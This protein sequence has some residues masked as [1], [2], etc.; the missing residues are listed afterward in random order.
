[1]IALRGAIHVACFHHSCFSMGV[2]RCLIE[3]VSVWEHVTSFSAQGMWWDGCAEKERN[4]IMY[5]IYGELLDEVLKVFPETNCR[6][7]LPAK[8]SMGVIKVIVFAFTICTTL[9]LWAYSSATIDGVTW[10]YMEKTDGT[11]EIGTESSSCAVVGFKTGVLS[12]PSEICDRP[13][14]GIGN[15]AFSECR[16]LTSVT[17]PSSVTSIGSSAFYRCSGLLSITIP[18][19]VTSIGDFTFCGC[20][21]LTSVVIPS[22][23]TSI[24]DYA[25]EGCSGLPSVTIPSCVTSIGDFAFSRCSG[26]TSV[27]IP[28]SVM[29]IGKG[30]F[31]YCSGLTSVT[32]SASVTSIGENAF[33][34]TKLV[35]DRVDGLVI[36]D[37]CLLSYMWVCPS[38]IV[39]PPDVRLI[40]DNAFS[41]CSGLTSV[42]IPE[43]V[44]SIGA[45]S[46]SGC[47]KMSSIS[48]N[49][50]NASY[51]S[52]DGVLYN[53]VNAELVCCPSG[54]VG[55]VAILEGVTSIGDYAF[56][57]CGGLTTVTIPSGVTSIGDRAFLNC[58]GLVSVTIP[59]SVER[60]GKSAFYGCSGLLSITIPDGVTSIEDS[61]FGRCSGLQTVTIP[62]SVTSIGIL[63]FGDCRGL[64]SVSIS[65]NAASI[66]AMAFDGCS[67]LTSVMIPSS[68]T[69]IGGLA[70]RGCSKLTEIVVHRNNLKYC[71][72]NGILYDK[73]NSELICCP[74][75]LTSVSIPFGVRSIGDSA[76]SACNG[77]TA[78]TIPSS[79]VSIGTYAFQNC[80]KLT[81]ITI[82]SSVTRIDYSALLCRKLKTIWTAKGDGER[83]RSLLNDHSSGYDLDEF[84]FREV[85]G[86]GGPYKETVGG[87]EWKFYVIDGNASLGNYTIPY[88]S[89]GEIVVP[90]ALG[91]CAVTSVG[92][93]AFFGF[94]GLSSVVIPM[95]VTS[96]GRDAFYGCSGLTSMVIPGCVT[97]IGRGA[98]YDCTALT[99][100]SVPSS[101]MKIDEFA[102]CG[103]SSLA[104]VVI[105]SGII[106][107]GAFENCSGLT[108]VTMMEGVTGVGE[109]A[110]YGCTGLESVTMPSSIMSVGDDAFFL[111]NGL[112]LAGRVEILDL[113][114]WCGISF[115]G[116]AANPL[117]NAKRF[118]INQVEVRDLTIPDG[119]THVGDYAFSG[120]SRLTSVT[121]PSSVTGVGKYAFFG[122]SG[123]SLITIPEGMAS[124][125]EYAFSDCTGLKSVTIPAGVTSI[126]SASFH[127]CSGL[128]VVTI[129]SSVEQIGSGTFFGCYSLSKVYVDAGDTERVKALLSDSGLQV[130]NLEFAERQYTV[131]FNGNGGEGS[132]E[133]QVYAYGAEQALASNKFSRTG[134]AFSGWAFAEDEKVVVFGDGEVVS[135]L[136]S[137]ADAV[138]PLYAVWEEVRCEISFDANGGMPA[139]PSALFQKDFPYGTLPESTRKGFRFLGWFTALD[140]G[141]QVTKDSIVDADRTLH[142]HWEEVRYSISFDANGGPSMP[143]SVSLQGEF[144]YGEL[145]MLTWSGYA[146]LG[147]FTSASGGMRITKD[148]IVDSERTLYAHWRSLGC[149]VKQND[150]VWDIVIAQLSGSEGVLTL[151]GEGLL[152]STNEMVNFTWQPETVGEHVFVYSIGGAIIE[153]I[154]VTVTTLPITIPTVPNPPTTP[155]ANIT[156]K[157][158]SHSFATEGGT[159]S[160]PT[161]GVNGYAGS[162]TVSKSA[163]WIVINSAEV[164]WKAGRS[165]VYTVEA[166]D[167]VEER[168]GF[169]YVGGHVHTITQ[170]GVGAKL[171]SYSANV[172]AEGGEGRFKVLADTGISWNARPNA[173]WITIS[174]TTGTGEKDVA[175]TVAPW[176]DVSTRSATITAAGGTF[177][178]N[179]FGRHMKLDRCAVSADYNAQT[180][181]LSVS[182]LP[183]IEWDVESS[184]PW[185]SIAGV[186]EGKGAGTV[187]LAV[188][189]NPS[190]LARTASVRI[191]TE[192]V[193][194]S[195]AKRPSAALNF[196]IDPVQ[197][198][199]LA[200]GG[201]GIVT[202][203]ATPGLPWS[204]QSKTDWIAL[205]PSA[206]TGTGNGDFTYIA[207]P[208]PAMAERSGTIKVSPEAASGLAGKTIVVVQ[209]AATAEISEEE[210]E[211]AAKGETFEI[212]VSVLDVVKWNITTVPNWVTIEGGT[213]RT[214]SGV[215]RV[216]AKENLSLEARE[217]TII[218]AGHEFKITQSGRTIKVDPSIVGVSMSGGDGTINVIADEN[219]IW[220]ASPSDMWISIWG[221]NDCD[222]DVDGSIVDVGSGAVNYYIDGCDESE[223]PRTGWIRIGDKRVNLLQTRDGVLVSVV[224][225]PG[226]IVAGDIEKGFVVKP[227][228]GKTA[229]EVLIPQ[230]IDAAKVTVEVSPN[231]ASVKPNGATVKVVNGDDD[232]TGFLVIPE[233]DGL[234]D[235]AAATVKEEIVKETLDPSKDAVIELNA[236]NPKLI[237]APTRKGL[238]YTLFEGHKLESLSKGDSKLGDGDPWKPTITVSGGD[239]AF[240]SIGVSK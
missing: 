20:S 13:V 122:C 240:Y 191:G 10:Y 166:N 177:T 207:E 125:G 158:T 92:A 112:I 11:V 169:V 221:D 236:A 98:F 75:G 231:V 40:A 216:T 65:E 18:P 205:L 226:V 119:V 162:I 189:E 222:Y 149:T 131:A 77:L 220:C 214:G 187:T 72:H 230:G 148:M 199:V 12:I 193:T 132:M 212:D 168:T 116:V 4:R 137:E 141:M 76:F 87:V 101:V 235:I 95:C 139:P 103:C 197:T 57:G 16:Q 54:K 109:R 237:T 6:N 147:W 133:R 21:G 100:V 228:G 29:S 208:N 27:T 157:Q 151:D 232:I 204:V 14:T 37:G 84:E 190:Y 90:P 215:V 150:L 127:G 8:N 185:I 164:N 3:D 25:F 23:V 73:A 194:I 143:M 156:I 33:V 56:E 142:A 159:F 202:V 86:N 60:I 55:D 219:V 201:T 66:G 110:F 227:S 50:G 102:F 135:N 184:A 152:S 30:A 5:K 7:M 238:T 174:P 180:V 93:D 160:I 128:R 34:G 2:C 51:Y 198:T 70:F 113:A 195:Q 71:S 41:H 82:P 167:G 203:A 68:V 15:G 47:S 39:I 85:L 153:T 239:A 129:P 165:I 52:V 121:I 74:N 170:A 69:S 48:V 140:G 91:G 179:Q 61:T 138:V 31:Y 124:I 209:S 94:S 22:S 59:S 218:I 62:S 42:T 225:D 88:G 120:C 182:A 111:C 146:F 19:N 196:A 223:L 161:A 211:F 17:M 36:V 163:S 188:D 114:K 107:E 183:F 154:I 104:T 130:S 224:D 53:K 99:A 28:M 233:S 145:P 173:N 38:E 97:N 24:G 9:C 186:G 175:F 217:A 44:T 126:G 67:G 79:V 81:S 192:T 210:H 105:P 213:T 108:E 63:A 80:D 32:I 206:V 117:W 35:N 26:L 171:G 115:G 181:D 106:G 43:G 45:C 46:F 200:A 134:F 83:I 1:M 96:I 58:S 234:M 118:Y 176:N 144:P 136:T 229:V 78:V 123:L 178:V 49:E 172:E 155:D 89:A 64:M